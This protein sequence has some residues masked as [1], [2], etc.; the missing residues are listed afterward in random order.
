[1]DVS[2]LSYNFNNFLKTSSIW[3]ISVRKVNQSHSIK[4]NYFYHY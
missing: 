2:K 4:E 3:K 1:M